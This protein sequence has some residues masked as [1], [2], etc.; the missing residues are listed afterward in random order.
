[1]A[2]RIIQPMLPIKT[3]YYIRKL[4]TT[5]L[6]CL[7][8]YYGKAQNSSNYISATANTTN[9]NLSTA[10]SL[11][12]EQTLSNAFT[13]DITSMNGPYSA[14]IRVFSTN[15]SSATPI[16]ANM[17]AVQLNNYRCTR[18]SFTTAKIPLSQTD[19]QLI[20]G[21]KKSSGDSYYYDLILAPIGYNYAPGTYTFTILF[22]MTQP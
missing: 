8:I 20:Q 3:K 2:A 18:C 15:S 11:E 21:T 4:L 17:L 5:C 1:M 14:Y 22:T 6:C 19:Q 10:N 16:P 13:L 12:T 9:F 7:F